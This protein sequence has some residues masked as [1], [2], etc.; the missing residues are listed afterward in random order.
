[1]TIIFKDY[2]TP[3]DET[4][5]KVCANNKWNYPFYIPGDISISR[6]KTDNFIKTNNFIQDSINEPLFNST[7]C[8]DSRHEIGKHYNIHGLY[9]H[10]MIET[11][12]KYL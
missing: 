7:I 11:T 2:L 6:N 4:P 10:Y 1:M 9:S 5:N 12:S 8:M 3:L